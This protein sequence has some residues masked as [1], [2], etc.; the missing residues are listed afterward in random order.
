MAKFIIGVIAGC[1]SMW[2]IFH[3][4]LDRSAQTHRVF[5]DYPSRWD[6]GEIRNCRVRQPHYS[7]N[8]WP[9]LECDGPG[10]KG[11]AIPGAH[12]FVEDVL[13]D[14]KFAI[15]PTKEQGFTWT[16][17]LLHDVQIECRDW[18]AIAPAPK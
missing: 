16:C 10:S 13:F 18:P 2:L 3:L 12:A 6:N 7:S 9:G 8:E 5:V 4:Q 14:G 17:Q 15:P 11:D 1:L